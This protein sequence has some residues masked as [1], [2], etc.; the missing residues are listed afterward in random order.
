[1]GTVEVDADK[2]VMGFAEKAGSDRPGLVNG[3]VYVFNRAVFEYIPEAPAS[4]ERDV[5]PRLLSHGVYALEQRGMFIDIG[6]PED[7]A[8]AQELCERLY[9]AALLQPQ[10]DSESRKC[11]N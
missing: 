9:K 2:R 4:L 8:R 7:Y 1:Y 5:F 3:G 10:T 6:T 11:G